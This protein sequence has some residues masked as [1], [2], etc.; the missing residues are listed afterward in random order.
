MKPYIDSRKTGSFIK[1]ERPTFCTRCKKIYN[2]IC[3]FCGQNVDLD[4]C[5]CDFNKLKL[6]E[7]TKYAIFIAM[8]Q[9]LLVDLFISILVMNKEPYRK[10]KSRTCEKVVQNLRMIVLPSAPYMPMPAWWGET[11]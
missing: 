3:P 11:I 6:T 8:T 10:R 2:G 1:N 5:I 7:D 4:E 9:F